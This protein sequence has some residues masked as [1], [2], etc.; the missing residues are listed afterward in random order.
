MAELARLI[1]A[2]RSAGH[3]PAPPLPTEKVVFRSIDELLNADLITGTRLSDKDRDGWVV[4]DDQ[5]VQL[6]RLKGK[7]ATERPLQMAA[8][9]PM[10]FPLTIEEEEYVLHG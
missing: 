3:I 6:F 2:A 9:S 4:C 8:M 7:K 10:W 5:K 1:R